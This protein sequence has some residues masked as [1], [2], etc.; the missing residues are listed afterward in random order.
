MLAVGTRMPGWVEAGYT[1]YAKR[2]PRELAFEL[3]EVKAESRTG[4]KPAEAAMAAEAQRLEDKLPSTCRRIVL[5]EHG[6][7]LSTRKL[8]DRLGAWM[9]DG[10]DVAIVIGG[11]DGLD[12][13]F[14][15][16]A[17]E[18]F[19]L[20]GLTL[21]HALVRVLLAEALYRAASLLRGHPY[22][23]E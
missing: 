14:K 20:S 10:R 9:Q 23:R 18:T 22:H 2:M 1:E 7:E 15:A 19:R 12:P 5:D 3:V 13:A 16:K 17:D 6:T 4:G 8:A 11:P 21:P